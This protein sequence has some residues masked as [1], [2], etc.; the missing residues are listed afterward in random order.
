MVNEGSI[1]FVCSGNTC[2]S[3]MAAA[4][5][6]SRLNNFEVASAG[7]MAGG[8]AATVEAISV[9]RRQGIDLSDHVSTCLK[10][11]MLDA[12]DLILVMTR[13]HAL[14]IADVVPEA[15]SR[16]FLLK[17]IV[18]LG[19]LSGRRRGVKLGAWIAS[20]GD[21]RT[22]DDLLDLGVATEVLDPVGHGLD[23]YEACRAELD[24]LTAALAGLLE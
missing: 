7:Y 21:A 4:M 14:Q 16:T 15:M 20:F 1:L 2:R 23:R 8:A 3:P 18:S 10:P 5:L 24:E 17:E 9:M 12:F 13:N 11:E 6:R 19:Q 22:V